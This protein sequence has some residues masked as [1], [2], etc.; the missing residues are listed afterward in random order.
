M[1]FEEDK[2]ITMNE[3]F[4]F[5]YILYNSDEKLRIILM[6]LVGKLLPLPLYFRNFDNI[7]K[8]SD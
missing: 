2:P 6:K 3:S 8:V 5:M 4:V 1:P 7:L